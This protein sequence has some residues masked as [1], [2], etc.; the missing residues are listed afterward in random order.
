M[1]HQAD[2]H[3]NYY[4]TGLLA[5][6][7]GQCHA[8][9]HLFKECLLANNVQNVMKT[10]VEPYGGYRQF[11]VNNIDFDDVNPTY[12]TEPVWK[13]A[14]N[15]RNDDLDIDATGIPGQNMSTPRTKLFQQHFL[16]H[17]TGDAT[18][19][20]PSYGVTT[21]GAS[22]FTTHSVGAWEDWVSGAWHWRKVSSAPS[23]DVTFSD[24]S[25]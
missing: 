13:Y 12:P 24:E 16:V 17:R 18:Y 7:D 25:W 3:D 21:T 23:V 2:G 4:R 10:R 22:D 15:D 14:Y 19:Y 6:A 9:A 1:H 8:W 5:D 20:D 11:G